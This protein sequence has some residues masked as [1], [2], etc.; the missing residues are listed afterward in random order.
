VKDREFDPE[1]EESIRTLELRDKAPTSPAV[2]AAAGVKFAISSDGIDNPKDVIRALKKSIDLGLK[3]EDALRALTLSAAEIYGLQS[4]LGSIDKGK[5]AN[6]IVTNG[7]LFD[8]KTKVQMI[9][10]DGVKYLPPPDAPET[11]SGR[12]AGARPPADSNE[13]EEQ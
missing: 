8:E 3:K 13:E 6:V 10:I 4:R 11:Q 9:F 2:L 7:D 1:R 12:G 5:I